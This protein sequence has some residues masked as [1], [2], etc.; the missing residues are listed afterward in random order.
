MAPYWVFLTSQWFLMRGGHIREIS[1]LYGLL[2]GLECSY[3]LLPGRL[4]WVEEVVIYK[5]WAAENIPGS[6]FQILSW[7]GFQGRLRA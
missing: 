3:W 5:R 1:D 2:G 6:F 4:P 7:V